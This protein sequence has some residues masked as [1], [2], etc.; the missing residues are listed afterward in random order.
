MNATVCFVLELLLLRQDLET[1]FLERLV[2][3]LTSAE[4]IGD[5]T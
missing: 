5:L 2:K 1:L 4:M 3:K